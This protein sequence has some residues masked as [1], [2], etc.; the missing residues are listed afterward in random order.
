MKTCYQ[1]KIKMSLLPLYDEIVKRMDGTE[2]TLK[3]NHCAS[4]ARMNV[5]NLEKI[6]LIILHHYFLKNGA[7]FANVKD[8]NLIPYGGKIISS[9]KGIIFRRLGQIPEDLQKIIYRYLNI[10]SN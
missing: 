3:K 6:Y 10:I 1:T 9:G 4:I 8:G 2:M 7:E 5:D